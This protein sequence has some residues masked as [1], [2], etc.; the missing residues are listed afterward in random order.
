MEFSKG[1]VIQLASSK[2]LIRDILIVITD[3]HF[4]WT[5]LDQSHQRTTTSLGDI[6]IIQTGFP[7]NLLKIYSPELNRRAFHVILK[8]RPMAAT[9]LAADERARDSILTGFHAVLELCG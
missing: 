2:G 8:G 6:G 4:S 3:S 7:H 9:F 5:L 1:V